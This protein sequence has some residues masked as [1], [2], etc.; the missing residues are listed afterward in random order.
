MSVYGRAMRSVAGAIRHS[1]MA[2]LSRHDLTGGQVSVLACATMGGVT[3]LSIGQGGDLGAFFGIAFVL[4]SLTAALA[5][6]VRSLYTPGVLPPLLLIGLLG[7]VAYVE[8]SAIDATGLAESASTTQ[9]VIA[10]VID[11]AGAL[12]AGHVLA[13]AAIAY[14]IVSADD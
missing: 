6:D 10:G 3:A 8:P 1:P 11:H 9:R 2:P 14:R 7:V 12:V 4:V 13:L 5:A